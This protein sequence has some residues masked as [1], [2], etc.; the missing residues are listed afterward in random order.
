MLSTQFS[1]LPCEL[2]RTIYEELCSDKLK[3][4]LHSSSNVLRSTERQ[5]IQFL[6]L[7]NLARTCKTIYAEA[8]EVM[9]ANMVI[10]VTCPD[11]SPLRALKA[12]A[13]SRGYL[14]SRAAHIRILEIYFPRTCKRRNGS[15]IPNDRTDYATV[16]HSTQLLPTIVKFMSQKFPNL[17]TLTVRTAGFYDLF[18]KSGIPHDYILHPICCALPRLRSIMFQT[19]ASVAYERSL[20]HSKTPSL[21]LDSDE[22]A[23]QRKLLQALSW[24]FNHN[25]QQPLKSTLV[26]CSACNIG[27]S[28]SCP[29]TLKTKIGKCVLDQT[30]VQQDA[31][32]AMSQRMEA[33]LKQMGFNGMLL[34][35]SQDKRRKKQYD[36]RSLK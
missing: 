1:R 31:G 6:N 35:Q 11:G 15:Y 8:I 22:F 14:N 26:H 12:L 7:F 23:R 36:L 24:V 20:V 5:R 33:V 28:Q 29:Y 18:E 30:D 16:F 4:S 10:S 9:Y 34:D 19:D 25:L 17:H 2:R 3:P 13:N 32:Q 21:L 27:N